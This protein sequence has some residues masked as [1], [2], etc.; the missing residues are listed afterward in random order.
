MLA[1]IAGASSHGL[2]F[3]LVLL[4]FP[5]GIAY[6]VYLIMAAV[7]ANRFEMYRVPNWACLQLV[8]EI[9]ASPAL[10]ANVPPCR[11]YGVPPTLMPTAWRQ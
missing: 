2:G 10:T 1:I 9:W 3:L 4:Y 11:P 7:A 6:I 5:L 8:H